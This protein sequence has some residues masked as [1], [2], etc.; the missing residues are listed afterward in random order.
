MR[1]KHKSTM[2]D[3]DINLTPLID[4]CFVILIMF[5]VVA[6]LLEFERIEL[7]A[8]PSREIQNTLSLQQQSSIVIQVLKDDTLM[9]NKKPISIQ[10]L[11]SALLQMKKIHPLAK[12]QLFQDQK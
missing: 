2:A 1:A 12:P 10:Q 5:I 3:A 7:A 4:I 8:A 11:T 9:L 6:P